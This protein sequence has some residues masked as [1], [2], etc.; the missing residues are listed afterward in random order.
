MIILKKTEIFTT[1]VYYTEF[2]LFINL[3]EY[4]RLFDALEVVHSKRIPPLP[5]SDNDN[6]LVALSTPDNFNEIPDETM[7]SVV[8]VILFRQQK[9]A[10]Q[11][12]SL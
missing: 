12:T 6:A 7:G 4:E 3:F 11:R 5:V 2:V 1:S 10:K 9:E 8:N